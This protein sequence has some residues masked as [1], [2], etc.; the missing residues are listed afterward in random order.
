MDCGMTA[1]DK[2]PALTYSKVFSEWTPCSAA[3]GGGTQIRTVT[4]CIG[5]DGVEALMSMHPFAA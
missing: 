5:L 1:C 4:Q 3:C 2:A